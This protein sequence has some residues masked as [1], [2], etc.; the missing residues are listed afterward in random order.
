MEDKLYAF[1]MRGELTKV[2]LN[3]TEVIGR[4]SLTRIYEEFIIRFI[5]R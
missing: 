5:G 2:A 1:I 3:K 4:F